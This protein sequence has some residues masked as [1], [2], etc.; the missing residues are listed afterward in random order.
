MTAGRASLL[1]GLWPPHLGEKRPL[2]ACAG[3]LCADRASASCPVAIGFFSA[4]AV[5]MAWLGL[6]L[7]NGGA[8]LERERPGGCLS[9]WGAS[10]LPAAQGVRV[11]RDPQIPCLWTK[12]PIL[13][14]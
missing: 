2:V 8:A 11:P 9:P 3:Q 10:V 6:L 7:Q 13:S 5:G 12:C 14:L 1:V 4:V